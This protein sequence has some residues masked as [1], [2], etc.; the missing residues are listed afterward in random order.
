MKVYEVRYSN[1]DTLLGWMQL[2]ELEC[3]AIEFPILGARGV[4]QLRL[5]LATF[6]AEGARYTVINADGVS[7]ELLKRI[8]RFVPNLN[9]SSATH[10]EDV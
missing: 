2:P 9:G 6:V 10:D 3:K 7:L 4:D 5:P 1:P 8:G